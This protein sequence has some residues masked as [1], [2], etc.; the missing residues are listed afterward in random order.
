MQK[1]YNYCA[2]RMT[3]Y[4]KRIRIYYAKKRL[5]NKSYTGDAGVSPA[6]SPQATRSGVLSAGSPQA[7]RSGVLSAGVLEQNEGFSGDCS[8]L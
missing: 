4:E 2:F 5:P 6:G 8:P 7:T 1:I 3:P